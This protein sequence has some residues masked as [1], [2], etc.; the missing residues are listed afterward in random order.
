MG[1]VLV[2]GV[3]HVDQDCLYVGDLGSD[4][5]RVDAR[6][7]YELEEIEQ[8]RLGHALEVQGAVAVV[9][10]FG[11]GDKLAAGDQAL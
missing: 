8:D 3:V 4:A 2:D 9:V 10:C 5:I 6:D 11:C 7:A 1:T